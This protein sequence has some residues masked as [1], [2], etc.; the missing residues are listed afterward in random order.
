MLLCT[1]ID[2]Y[3]QILKYQQGRALPG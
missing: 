3:L 1:I 2:K